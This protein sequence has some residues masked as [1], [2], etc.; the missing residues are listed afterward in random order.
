MGHKKIRKLFMV[1]GEVDRIYL[2][3]EPKINRQKRI[4]AGG[5]KRKCFTEG[6]VE[7]LDKKAA[8]RVALMFNGVIT[9]GKKQHNFYREDI[10][11]IKYL[12]KFTWENL[13]HKIELDKQLAD[14][15]VR[16]EVALSRKANRFYAQQVQKSR[17]IEGIQK[18]R[19]RK[20]EKFIRDFPQK[21]PV[22][23]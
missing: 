4:K 21:D 10:W 8:K 19:K 7:F 1:H 18:K 23:D 14:K 12:P 9:G 13:T 15:Q 22:E 17:E 3:P 20:E 16:N 6:W 11:N 5:N 2:T